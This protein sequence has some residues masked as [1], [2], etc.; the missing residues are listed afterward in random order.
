[1]CG[2]LYNNMFMIR[3]TFGLAGWGILFGM[4]CIVCTGVRHYK[5]VDKMKKIS[6]GNFMRE[7]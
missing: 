4:C 5:Q 6:D 1:M 7:A 3:M 2:S